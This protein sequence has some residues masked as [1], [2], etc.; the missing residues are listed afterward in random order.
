MM[1]DH[2]CFRLDSFPDVPFFIADI[3]DKEED[4]EISIS[5]KDPDQEHV[6]DNPLFR[7][8]VTKFLET[9]I[10]EAMKKAKEKLA[11][12]TEEEDE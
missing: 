8:E 6:L 3:S 7:A 9:M 5:T 4:V 12:T 2:V 10:N 11:A 1:S